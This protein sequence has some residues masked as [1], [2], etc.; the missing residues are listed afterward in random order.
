MSQVEAL[1]LPAL[2][3]YLSNYL[4]CHVHGRYCQQADEKFNCDRQQDVYV[5]VV[6]LGVFVPA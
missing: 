4:R 2:V 1:H 5:F 6:V 3:V